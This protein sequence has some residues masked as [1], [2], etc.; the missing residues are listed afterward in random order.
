MFVHDI[1]QCMFHYYIFI[2]Y[3]IYQRYILNINRVPEF[4]FSILTKIIQIAEF[5]NNKNK[6]REGKSRKE[7]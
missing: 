2:Y 3:I 4:N 6:Y 7:E 1:P 5:K